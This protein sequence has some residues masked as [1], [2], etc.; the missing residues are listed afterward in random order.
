MIYFHLLQSSFLARQGKARAKQ[1]FGEQSRAAVGNQHLG[2]GVEMQLFVTP[3]AILLALLIQTWTPVSSTDL[4]W[5]SATDPRSLV[6]AAPGP[7]KCKARLSLNTL[8]ET[9]ST[10]SLCWGSQKQR[11]SDPGFNRPGEGTRAESPSLYS[12]AGKSWELQSPPKQKSWSYTSE[13]ED[14]ETHLGL[15]HQ[16]SQKSGIHREVLRCNSKGPQ[17]QTRL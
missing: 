14:S 6:P 13:P 12:M 9:Q 5:G 2:S 7:Y 17:L 10:R 4:P 16:R 1:S 15:Q 8:T 11:P 3:G